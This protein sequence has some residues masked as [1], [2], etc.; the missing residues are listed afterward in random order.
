MRSIRPRFDLACPPGLKPAFFASWIMLAGLAAAC[1]RA[2]SGDYLID[3]WTAENGLPNSSVTAIAQTPDGYLWVGTYNGLARFDG[4]Q[5]VTFDPANTPA[6]LRARVRKLYVDGAGTLWINTYDGSLTSFR[7]RKF[8][9]EWKGDGSADANVASVFSNNHSPVFLLYSGELIVPGEN[10]D[11]RWKSIRPPGA[12]SGSLCVRDRDGEV[13]GRGR[14]QKLWR[15][16][17]GKFELMAAK[18]GLQGTTINCLVTDAAGRVWAGTEKEIAVWDGA[19]FRSMTPTNEETALNVSFLYIAPGGDVWTISNER[20]RKARDRQWVFEAEA[21]R[22]MLI[23]SVDRLGIQQDRNGG[24]W[25]YHYGKG[26][27]HLRPDG[28]IRQVADEQGFPG[29][30][31]DCFYEDH[32]GNLWAGVDRGG[33]VRLRQKRFL[34]LTPEG[35]AAAVSVSEDRE[36]AIW[37][38]TFG[39]GLHCWH[40]GKW[41]TFSL[42]GGTHRGFVFSLCSDGEGRLWASA[43]DEDLFVRENGQFQRKTPAV[44]GVKALLGAADGRVWVGTKSGLGFWSQGQFRYLRPTDGVERSDFRALAEDTQGAIWAGSGNG[45]LYRMDSNRVDS[46]Q[47][48]DALASQPIWSLCA[49]ADGT[50]WIGSFRGGLLRFRN[51]R[52]SRYTTSQG[53]PDDI[54]C[55]I[56][57]DEKGRLWIGSQQGIFSVSKSELDDF[58]SGES[59][60]VNCTA[61]GRYDGLPSLECSGSYQPAACR[62]RDGRL[63]FATLKGVVSVKPD[64][65]APNKLPPPVVIEEVLVD[66]EKQSLL[67]KSP[68]AK[69]DSGAGQPAEITLE[70]PPGKRQVEFRFSGLSFVSPDRVRFR[71]KLEGLDRDFIEGGTRRS[72]QYSF[73]RPGKYRFNVTACNNEGVWSE[74]PAVLALNILPHFYEAWWF[75]PLIGLIA[76]GTVAGTVRHFAVKRFRRELEQLERQRA[77]ERD[78]TRI[79]KDIH[80]DLGAGLTQITLLSELA[81]REPPEKLGDQLE[82]ISDSARKLTRTIDEIVWAIDPQHDTL[83]GVMDYISAYTE[84]FLRMAGIRCRMDLPVTLPAMPVS[85]E[86]RYNLFLAVK[87]TLNN[88]VKHAEASEVSLSLRLAPKAFTLLVQDNGRGLSAKETSVST[89]RLVCGHGLSNLDN[90]LASI[91]GRCSI[92]S[93]SGQGTRVE[94]WVNLDPASSPVVAIGSTVADKVV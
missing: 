32:E 15:L 81:R 49:D 75:R 89:D 60:S 18:A 38:G 74:A 23:G 68:P 30:R 63:L 3:V 51:G 36:G 92:H 44:H 53:L 1:G 22:Q 66:G 47:P 58:A 61:Y 65:L 45:K 70:V 78:R 11:R 41:Q 24:L 55:Q 88:I 39:A 72:A 7:D 43:G 42:P 14:D 84:D 85:A 2:G 82:R 40:E 67:P 12:S 33:L 90:R 87:E 73:L 17:Q 28:G 91:G 21:C 59:R 79:A 29:E 71:Y 94:M 48:N 52:F 93:S 31:V 46:F 13:W 8:T 57:D 6:L 37:I 9:L 77:V 4:V 25:V 19:Q 27:F 86:V 16:R 83:S 5:F 20:L 50:M 10:P 62:T 76:I 69:T 54:I 56:L 35:N 80:D 26:I 64:Q 34:A